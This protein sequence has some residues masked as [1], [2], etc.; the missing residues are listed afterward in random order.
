MTV[1]TERVLFITNTTFPPPLVFTLVVRE[2]GDPSQNGVVEAEAAQRDPQAG[3]QEVEMGP[4]LPTTLA[5]VSETPKTALLVLSQHAAGHGL[6]VGPQY[7]L[8]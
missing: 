3:H 5:L 7:A 2:V 6:C 4:C 8:H 1:R